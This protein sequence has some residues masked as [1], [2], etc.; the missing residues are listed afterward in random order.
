MSYDSNMLDKTFAWG[1]SVLSVMLIVLMC[2]VGYCYNYAQVTERK[3]IESGYCQVLNPGQVNS[4]H[5]TKC[6][7]IGPNETTK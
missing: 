1:T 6:S 2:W 7:L 3:A 4:Y 5:W